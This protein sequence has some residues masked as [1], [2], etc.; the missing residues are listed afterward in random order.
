MKEKEEIR[1]YPLPLNLW[2]HEYGQ[3]P[4]FYPLHK[5]IL[6]TFQIAKYVATTCQNSKSFRLHCSISYHPSS[7]SWT[8]QPKKLSLR[9]IIASTQSQSDFSG[10]CSYKRSSGV[11]WEWKRGSK[12]IWEL[13]RKS[14]KI[15]CSTLKASRLLRCLSCLESLHQ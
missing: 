7:W 13:F 11:I 3:C 2:Q 9:D 1:F 6:K 12:F 15:S 8:E 10:T 5:M 4:L 14:C